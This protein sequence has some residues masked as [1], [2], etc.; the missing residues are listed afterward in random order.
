MKYQEYLQLLND[1]QTK[2]DSLMQ[3]V[4]EINK[5]RKKIDEEEQIIKEKITIAKR[6]NQRLSFLYSS[7]NPKYIRKM[8]STFLIAYSCCVLGVLLPFLLKSFYLQIL[9]QAASLVVGI[10]AT[11][12]LKPISF[13]KNLDQNKKELKLLE[14][15]HNNDEEKLQAKEKKLKQRDEELSHQMWENIHK[16]DALKKERE[17]LTKN[18]KNSLWSFYETGNIDVPL[19]VKKDD[20]DKP[21]ELIRK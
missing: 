19:L 18:L 15:D 6:I 9:I 16:C 14:K 2:I 12:I 17:D 7:T 1:Y 13:F 4:I 3:K 5:E 8:K 10:S 11:Y 20:E 21:K